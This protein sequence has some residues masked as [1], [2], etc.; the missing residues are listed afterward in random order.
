MVNPLANDGTHS[1]LDPST[2]ERLEAL[3]LPGSEHV[4]APGLQEARLA[5]LEQPGPSLAMGFWRR[6]WMTLS[7]IAILVAVG[8]LL[9]SNATESHRNQ[10]QID[11]VRLPVCS[12]MYTALSHAPQTQAQA[13]VRRDYLTA[14]GPDG[15]NCPKPLLQGAAQ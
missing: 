15:L 13:N 9:A 12:I 2:E 5:Y 10:V 7:I 3:H 11:K 6:R 4:T 14:Y 1:P 8:Y